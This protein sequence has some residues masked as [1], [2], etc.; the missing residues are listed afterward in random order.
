MSYTDADQWSKPVAGIDYIT[1]QDLDWG[2]WSPNSKTRL[3]IPAGFVFNV[4]I[5]KK[6]RWALNPHDPRFRLAG[7]IHDY[8]LHVEGARHIRVSGDFHDALRAT[9]TPR[10]LAIIMWLVVSLRKYR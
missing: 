9:N 8:L 5:P 4:S 10:L 1:T 6:L 2:I 7:A 3:K